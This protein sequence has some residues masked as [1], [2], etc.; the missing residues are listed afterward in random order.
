MQSTIEVISDVVC[1]WCYIGKRRLEQ[2]L[3]MLNAEGETPVVNWRPFQLNPDMPAEGVARK[4]YVESKFGGPERARGIYARVAGVG[5]DVGIPFDF[6]KIPRQPN[7]I[8]AHRLIEFAQGQGK[9]DPVVE[10]LFQG[11]FLNGADIGDIET[12]AKIAGSAGLNESATHA[13]LASDQGVRE[14]QA[15]DQWARNAGVSGVPFFVFDGKVAVSGAQEAA[16]LVQAYRSAQA[17][18]SAQ[19]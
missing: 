7:T 1:P 13:Y 15:A 11:F 4:Q 14:T 5:T 9:Q 16:V 6:E 3:A 2:A 19:V 12:L 10:A 8:H 18:Q 17:K